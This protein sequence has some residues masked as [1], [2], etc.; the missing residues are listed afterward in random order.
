MTN[1][2]SSCSDI[3]RRILIFL[4]LNYGNDK[5]SLIFFTNYMS[6]R[7]GNL[8]DTISFFEDLIMFLID[9]QSTK[10]NLNLD[11]EDYTE[12]CIIASCHL[13]D[14]MAKTNQF[15]EIIIKNHFLK[16]LIIAL[17]QQR[18]LVSSEILCRIITRIATNPELVHN[19]V[20]FMGYSDIFEPLISSFAG[21]PNADI[22]IKHFYKAFVGVRFE[23]VPI[24]LSLLNY[25][26]QANN[27]DVR[28]GQVAIALCYV[29]GSYMVYVMMDGVINLSNFGSWAPTF[30]QGLR[31][32][33]FLFC[34]TSDHG[35][36]HLL[37]QNAHNTM[38][39][40][41]R[42]TLR[43]LGEFRKVEVKN[44][45][46]TLFHLLENPTEILSGGASLEK[47]DGFIALSFPDDS[48][49]GPIFVEQNLIAEASPV[50]YSMLSGNYSESKSKEVVLREET[51]V[52]WDL[53]IRYLLLCAKMTS[54]Q[55]CK[56]KYTSELKI[57]C[58]KIFLL[59]RI[60]EKFMIDKIA[61]GC[62]QWLEDCL[63]IAGKNADWDLCFLVYEQFTYYQCYDL[64]YL[65]HYLR[66][67]EKLWIRSM[68]LSLCARP[69]K[70][71]L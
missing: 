32:W 34:V 52:S 23:I 68:I 62:F 1:I 67:L 37:S 59:V 28:E 35:A 26:P 71:L 40:L 49:S 21:S 42:F 6:I 39:Y 7:P 20:V 22:Y 13:L 53:C 63:I 70:E 54:N 57:F 46:S 4:N 3:L 10:S 27:N 65:Q 33:K 48:N 55:E 18:G 38:N 2:S 14:S 45:L 5:T 17:L 30:S 44:N 25:I 36:S 69:K 56:L 15:Q 60:S 41:E 61:E 12:E 58:Q 47:N 51:Y 8:F 64:V 50:I 9:E 66:K 19:M 29:L 11:P 43:A 16:S 31:V 24:L